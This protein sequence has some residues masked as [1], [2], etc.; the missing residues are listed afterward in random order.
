MMHKVNQEEMVFLHRQT[1]PRTK[2]HLTGVQKVFGIL[3]PRYGL[4][5]TQEE[6][7]ALSTVFE[8]HMNA[9]DAVVAAIVKQSDQICKVAL[10]NIMALNLILASDWGTCSAINS[11]EFCVFISDPTQEVNAFHESNAEGV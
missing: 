7:T 3:S 2:S 9:Y 5:N 4:Y 10:Q 8:K 1:L 11:G 6:L